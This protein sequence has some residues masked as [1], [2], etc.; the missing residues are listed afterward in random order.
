MTD[1][2]VDDFGVRKIYPTNTHA[3]RAK[4]WFMGKDNWLERKYN[5]VGD[6]NDCPIST[7]N[8]GDTVIK[9]R[10]TGDKGRLPVLAIPMEDYPTYTTDS[11]P[12]VVSRTDQSYLRKRGFMGTKNDWKNL[13]VTLY[14]KTYATYD[15]PAGNNGMGFSV[16]GGPHHSDTF[17][18]GVPCEGTALYVAVNHAGEATIEKE[19]RHPKYSKKVFKQCFDVSRDLMGKWIGMKGIFYTKANGNPYIEFWFDRNADNNWELLLFHE[20]TKRWFLKEDEDEDGIISIFDNFG[21]LT[22][23]SAC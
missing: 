6:W 16:R 3:N 17:I 8:N 11:G 12:V 18:V 10:T 20:D 19:L 2:M 23:P 22:P 5:G 4:P 7:D 15:R 13:E 14:W 21:N 9:F 1:I